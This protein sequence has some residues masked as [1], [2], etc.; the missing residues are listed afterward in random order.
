MEL[1]SYRVN[2]RLCRQIVWTRKRGEVKKKTKKTKK[3]GGRLSGER[4]NVAESCLRTSLWLEVSVKSFS[5]TDRDLFT[6][7][8]KSP[9]DTWKT[10]PAFFYASIIEERAHLDEGLSKTT[11][12]ENAACPSWSGLNKNISIFSDKITSSQWIFVFYTNIL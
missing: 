3:Q 1:A 5:I 12:E 9:S 2:E 10:K 11:E 4:V 7:A 6:K 8:S